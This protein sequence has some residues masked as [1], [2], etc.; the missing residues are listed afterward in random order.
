[1]SQGS[2]VAV[3]VLAYIIWIKRK[4]RKYILRHEKIS[5]YFRE[6]R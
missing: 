4:S 5:R 3:G 2:A 6:E 1:M